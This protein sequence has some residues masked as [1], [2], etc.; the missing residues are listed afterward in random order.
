[1][2][3]SQEMK[4]LERSAAAHGII[5]LELMENAGRRVAEVILERCDGQDKQVVIFAGAGNNGGDGLVAAR[6]LRKYCQTL[7]LLFGEKKKL[8]EEALENYEKIKKHVNILPITS[9]EDLEKFHFQTN[10]KYILVDALVGTGIKGELK[11]PVSFAIDYFNSLPGFKVAVDMPS[12]MDPD[13]GEGNNIC[14]VDLVVTFHD[15]K[16]ALE[17]LKEKTVVVDIGIP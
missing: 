9:K 1:M 13:T 16:P 3:T 17:K 14:Q 2:I 8:P 5:P 6:Y 11:E 7:V 4:K 10:L 12:G 15:F